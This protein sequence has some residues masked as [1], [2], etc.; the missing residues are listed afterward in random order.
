[1]ANMILM[2]DLDGDKD[3]DVAAVA[4]HGSYEFRWW[5][6]EGRPPSSPD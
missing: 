1:M 3:L 4:E 5:R 6:N 2:A